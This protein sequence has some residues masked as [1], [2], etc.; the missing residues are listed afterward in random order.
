MHSQTGFMRASD[1]IDQLIRTRRSVFTQQFVPAKPVPDEI[2]W[3]ALENAN[4]APT[5]KL[6]EPWRFTVFTGN[7]LKKL[8]EEQAAVYKQFA[9]AGFRQNKYEQ[10]L[11]TPELCS[12]VIAVGCKRHPGQVPE[13]EEIAAVACA[14]QN[15]YLTL[16][17]HEGIGCYWSTGGITF[18]EEAKPLFGLGPGDKLM[19]FIYVGQVRVP[20]APGRRQPIQEK[21][22]WVH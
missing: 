14:V 10:M 3:Q 20:S 22:T 13:M 9:G 1:L 12:H 18:I 5:H 6:T 16:T 7:G 21:V 11:V 15:I 19:G 17:A 4:W 8:A 2:I